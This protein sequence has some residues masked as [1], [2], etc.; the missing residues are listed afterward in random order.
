MSCLEG[1]ADVEISKL[2]LIQ[3]KFWMKD[4]RPADLTRRLWCAR[5]SV[6]LWTMPP[7]VEPIHS[8][9][10]A[11]ASAVHSPESL[12][13]NGNRSA[14]SPGPGRTQHDDNSRGYF[15]LKHCARHNPHRA[16]V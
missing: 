7:Y 4:L 13:A 15:Q 14:V 6:T 8:R 3:I 10:P 2:T 5:R 11:T 12:G 16:S 9:A 1:L